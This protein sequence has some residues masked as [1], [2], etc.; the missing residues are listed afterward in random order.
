MAVVETVTFRLASDTDEDDFLRADRAMQT[1]FIPN[2]PGF[3][4]RTTARSDDGEWLVVTLWQ[5]QPQA[6]EGERLADSSPVCR[7]FFD[8]VDRETL[9]VKRYSTL[10]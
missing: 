3:L 6:L 7:R 10:D 4:R 2:L 5:S 1:E 9:M 8:L